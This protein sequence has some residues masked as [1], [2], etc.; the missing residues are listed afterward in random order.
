MTNRMVVTLEYKDQSKTFKYQKGK[1][2][3][4]ASWDNCRNSR[5]CLG[6]ISKKQATEELLKIL[7]FAMESSWTEGR[8]GLVNYI[9]SSGLDLTIQPNVVDA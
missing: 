2:S 5:Y 6:L 7:K 1:V 9:F 3:I 8:K 4:I